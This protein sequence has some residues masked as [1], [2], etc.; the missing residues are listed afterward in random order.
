MGHGLWELDEEEAG[1]FLALYVFSSYVFLSFNSCS[2][3]T[4]SFLLFSC[5]LG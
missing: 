2:Y 1:L 3:T 4:L 5:D